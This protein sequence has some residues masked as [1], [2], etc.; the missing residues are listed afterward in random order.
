MVLLNRF[1]DFFLSSGSGKK[2]FYTKNTT[3]SCRAKVRAVEFGLENP[4]G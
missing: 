1:F 3:N 2:V 4:I